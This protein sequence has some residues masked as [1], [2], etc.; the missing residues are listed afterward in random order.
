MARNV[1]A[2]P[3]S[4]GY[5]PHKRRLLKFV[6]VRGRTSYR[7]AMGTATS[8]WSAGL[9]VDGMEGLRVVDASLAP[10]QLGYSQ[11][12][13]VPCLVNGFTPRVGAALVSRIRAR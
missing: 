2:T 9:P 7:C 13:V 11:L 12:T 6:K 5:S 4:T 8:R 3:G 10:G 1:E